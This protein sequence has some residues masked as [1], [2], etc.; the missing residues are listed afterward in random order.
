MSTSEPTRVDFESSGGLKV[1]AYRWDP[2]GE[3]R[4]VVQL[5]HG[6]GEHAMRYARLAAALTEQGF[7]VYAQ[8]HRGHG[9]TARS[10][11]EL[12]KL[13]ENGWLE[14]V[15]DIDRLRQVVRGEH[16]SVP[17]VLIGHSMGS[18]AAQQYLLDHSRDLDV[19]VLTG[20]AAI[21]LLEPSL[22]L[23]V[24]MDLSAFNARFA[25]ARTDYDWLSRDEAEVDKYVADPRCGFGLDAESGKGMF[26]GARRLTFH[27]RLSNMKRDVPIYVAV[28]EDDPVNGELALVQALVDR[29]REAG[30]EEV[31]LKTYAGARHEVFNETNRDE[32]VADLL[33]FVEDRLAKIA[34]AS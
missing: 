11:D 30:M 22:D 23:D 9:R 14:L 27:E 2:T 17:L 25:P 6:M 18:F 33:A 26:E 12:G 19:V 4:A 13:G 10:D 24:P 15:E 7:A 8:D 28:G 32:V 20:T 21:D 1:A 29:L 31:T 3:P 16:P 34:A 5:T